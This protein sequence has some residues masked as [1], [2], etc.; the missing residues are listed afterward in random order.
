MI[1]KGV[2]LSNSK[3]SLAKAAIVP[4]IGR[5]LWNWGAGLQGQLGDNSISSKSS[6]VQ[7]VTRGTNWA[8]VTSAFRVNGG[9]KQDGT[10]WLWGQNG[11][12]QLGTNDTTNRSSPVQTVAGGS[13]WSKVANKSN[14]TG[15]IKTDGTLWCWGQNSVGSLGTN[16]RTN[17][18]SPIQTV[19]GGS[20]W[21]KITVT[22][23]GM[24]AT[25][26]DGTLWGWGTNTSGELADNTRVNKSSPV[27]TVA[28][29]SNWSEVSGGGATCFATK[30]DGTLW[31]WGSGFYG[32]TGL[33]LNSVAAARSSPVQTVAFGSNWS[34]ISA[35][36]ETMCAS[37]TDG[38]LWCWG[39]NNQG[40]CG[41]GDTIDRSS[42]VQTIAGGSNW[43]IV[44][45]NSTG[46]AAIKTDGTLWLWGNNTYGSMGNN[47]TNPG[48]GVSSPVQTIMGG[49]GWKDAKG[50]SNPIAIY[51]FV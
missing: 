7:T 20:N 9:I 43:S 13:N 2:K 29:G 47:T 41:T 19:A 14:L 36:N 35:G 16:D 6:P 50:G 40:Q 25:K 12:G 46:G 15:A 39:R 22:D 18:S 21:S 48:E 5:T 28:G 49:T 42:P 33:N 32:Q 3:F 10:L 27:Q 30:T 34:K 26:T 45:Q 4:L 37:K 11:Q 8:S 31:I 38:T 44:G 23:G 17:R 24:L 51:E 1:I